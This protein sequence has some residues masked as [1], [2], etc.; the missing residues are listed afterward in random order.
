M[1]GLAFDN[2]SVFSVAFY[3][4][5]KKR[6]G[7]SVGTGSLCQVGRGL[8]REAEKH[9]A[10]PSTRTFPLEHVSRDT[11]MTTEI[12]ESYLVL[13]HSEYQKTFGK[14]HR[15][16]DAK[17][18]MMTIVNGS[19]HQEQVFVFRNPEKPVREM[20]LRTKVGETQSVQL[21]SS[22]GHHH[23]KQG[24]ETFTAAYTSRRQD[25]QQQVIFGAGWHPCTIDEHRA[26]LRG[27]TTPKEAAKGSEEVKC[28][29][30]EPPQESEMM[31]GPG[32]QLITKGVEKQMPWL[33]KVDMVDQRTPKMSR[34]KSCQSL[35]ASVASDKSKASGDLMHD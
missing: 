24:L 9:L 27:D 23:H 29:M 13:N 30:P 8:R 10:D 14:P 6:K 34:S 3:F 16:K 15:M 12:L 25:H 22:E 28:E 17:V 19:N 11:Q 20:L 21:L 5:T 18:P 26:K 2:T 32:E 7:K 1:K 31:Q 35:S 33:G 4:P